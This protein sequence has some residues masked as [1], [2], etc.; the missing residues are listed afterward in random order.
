MKFGEIGDNSNERDEVD[1]IIVMEHH[2]NTKIQKCHYQ[3][4]L[5]ITIH[6]T[7]KIVMIP[8]LFVTPV[9]WIKA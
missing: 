1:M 2:V 9:R 6:N 4:Q 8:L 3:K 7:H 5:D